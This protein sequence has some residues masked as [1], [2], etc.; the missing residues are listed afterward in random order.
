ELNQITGGGLW[1]DLLY[2]INRYAH[3]IT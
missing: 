1:E 3:Y 2:N